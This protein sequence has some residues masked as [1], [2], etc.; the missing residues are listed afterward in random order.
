MVT[1]EQLE[2]AMDQRF[3]KEVYEK[4]KQA[5]ICIAGLG[6]LGSNI[7]IMLARSGIGTLKLIDFDVVDITNLNRQAYRIEH[8]DRPKTEALREIIGEINP[9]IKIEVIQKKVTEENLAELFTGEQ[10]V[11]E[12]FDNPEYKAMLVNYLLEQQPET[13]VVSGSGMAGVG[14]SNRI[15]TRQK[16]K[17]LYVCGDEE[18]DAYAGMGLLS[19]RVSICAG[20]QANMLLRLILGEKES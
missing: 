16:M 15:C 3:S 9:Y 14:S 2:Q 10:L 17:R 12:A 5:R 4:F 18:S 19:P 1:R 20:H 7:A 13:I 8:I 6:G 11:C